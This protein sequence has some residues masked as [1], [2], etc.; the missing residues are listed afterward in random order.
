M[1]CSIC[2]VSSLVVGSTCTFW[3]R[4]SKAPSF[5]MELRYSSSVVAPIH[6]MV[7][8][9]RAGFRM[10]AASME[11]GVAPAPI[12]VCISSMKM[13]MSGFCS[14]SLTS[15]FMRSS[16]CPRYLVP[17]T[18]P[19][20]SSV[21]RRLLKSMGEQWREAIICASPSTMALLP[22]PGSP[23][24]MGLFFLRR[25]RISMTRCISAVRPTQGSSF[26]SRACWVRSVP[27]L[28]STGVFDLVFCWVV[29][30]VVLA[31]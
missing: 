4:R 5:S 1:L 23:M 2:R 26:D 24:R 9:A 30:W 8:R 14:N 27:K 22:T 21:T 18:T 3:K 7:P 28:S 15:I 25:P 20:M 10:L 19:V 16:N 11:P 13:M 17:A 6:C 31:D 29:V 12:M